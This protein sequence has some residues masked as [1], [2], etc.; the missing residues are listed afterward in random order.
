M[1][2]P[3]ANSGDNSPSPGEHHAI[4]RLLANRV[5]WLGRQH[6]RDGRALHRKIDRVSVT[7]NARSGVICAGAGRA[8]SVQAATL[9]SKIVGTLGYINT[10]TQRSVS[11]T[12][13]RWWT[14]KQWTRQSRY[15]SR[16]LVPV[17]WRWRR[18]FCTAA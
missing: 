9:E 4:A 5:P 1:T 15:P 6:V 8:V 2:V 11:S 10:L 18:A 12:L 17:R 14:A 7:P 13:H 3:S 16:A